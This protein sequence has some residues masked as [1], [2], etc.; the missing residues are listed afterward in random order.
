M[1][2]RGIWMYIVPTVL[3]LA[4]G[5]FLL[6][7]QIQ[8]TQGN[9]TL[10]SL[11]DAEG[12]VDIKVGDFKLEKQPSMGDTKAKVKV[13]EFVD[14][15]CPVCRQWELQYGE[16][17]KREF[18]DTG[19]VQFYSINFPFLG[20]DSIE[21]ALAAELVNEQGSDKFWEF[22]KKLYYKQQEQ[23]EQ[24]I[25]ATEKFMLDFVKENVTGIDY[26]R[27]AKDLK[28]RKRL[29]DVKEDFKI[30]SANGIYSTPTFIVNGQKVV[31]MDYEQLSSVIH[32]YAY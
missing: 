26:K 25:W 12:Q 28:D 11:M 19:M 21:A 15:K 7:Q 31:G 18:V 29:I 17:F 5:I 4:F 23:Q 8:A 32:H 3:V 6:T 24:T 30:S 10:P 14:F 13:I 2:N 22:K 27:F 1:K 16:Q 9:E 20:P